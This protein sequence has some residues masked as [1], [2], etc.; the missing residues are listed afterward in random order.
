MSV[1]RMEALPINYYCKPDQTP[2][3]VLC[4]FERYLVTILI[5]YEKVSIF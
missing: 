4:I 3:I 5:L 2:L 1:S